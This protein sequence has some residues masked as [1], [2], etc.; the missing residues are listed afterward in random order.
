MGRSSRSSM[1]MAH[2]HGDGG[3]IIKYEDM[4]L[5]PR[6]GQIE[7]IILHNVLIDDKSCVHILA[8][9]RWFAKPNENVLKYYGKPVEACCRS[10]DTKRGVC[11]E[12]ASGYDGQQHEKD[13]SSKHSVPNWQIMFYCML[14]VF[15]VSLII[16]GSL[17]KCVHS[18][19]NG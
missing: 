9:V 15:G 7:N 16:N 4:E 12:C 14:G 5:C 17:V 3:Q 6:P 11:E 2:W 13:S 19:E 8:Q 1:I 10:C 18:Q